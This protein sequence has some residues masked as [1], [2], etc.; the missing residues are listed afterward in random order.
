VAAHHV[1][2]LAEAY[3]PARAFPQSTSETKIS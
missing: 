3:W 2:E 1:Q